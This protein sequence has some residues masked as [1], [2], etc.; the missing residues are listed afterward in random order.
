MQVQPFELLGGRGRSCDVNVID[1][2]ALAEIVWLMSLAVTSNDKRFKGKYV[3]ANC[4][5]RPVVWLKA[6]PDARAKVGDVKARLTKIADT[7]GKKFPWSL[8]AFNN[9]P[10]DA[11]AVKL[12]AAQLRKHSR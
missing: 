2:D 6:K 10:G 4:K 12:I 3:L 1:D 8:R 5:G 9:S 7:E 11:E